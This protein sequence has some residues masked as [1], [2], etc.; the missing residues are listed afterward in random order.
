MRGHMT[1]DR[2]VPPVR[3][4]KCSLPFLVLL[5]NQTR[6][7]LR[8]H[9][10][11]AHYGLAHDAVGAI[12]GMRDALTASCRFAEAAQAFPPLHQMFSVMGPAPRFSEC[13]CWPRPSSSSS[14][15][16]KASAMPSSPRITHAVSSR[17]CRKRSATESRKDVMN[18]HDLI[19][20]KIENHTPEAKKLKWMSARKMCHLRMASNDLKRSAITFTNTT[21]TTATLPLLFNQIRVLYDVTFRHLS[22]TASAS[23][24]VQLCAPHAVQ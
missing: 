6:G 16:R 24:S 3:P 8:A 21:S 19:V 12:H 15:C 4:P 9:D 17:S 22:V 13:L 11:D 2:H 20:V 14:S 18:V 5:Y 1:S 10:A 7:L 23:G